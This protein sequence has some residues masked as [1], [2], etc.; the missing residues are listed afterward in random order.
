LNRQG[1]WRPHTASGGLRTAHPCPAAKPPPRPVPPPAAG[2]EAAD[3]LPSPHH[4]P[5]PLRSPLPIPLSQTQPTIMAKTTIKENNNSMCKS[6]T[7]MYRLVLPSHGMPEP[8]AGIHILELP[9]YSFCESYGQIRMNLY[10][11]PTACACPTQDSTTR[12][13]SYTM[14]R[15]QAGINKLVLPS[16]AFARRRGVIVQTCTAFTLHEQDSGRG[17]GVPPMLSSMMCLMSRSYDCWRRRGGTPSRPYSPIRDRRMGAL[18]RLFTCAAS[19]AKI[20]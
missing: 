10:C 16:S 9:P 20:A 8:H 1:G 4:V 5:N 15:S 14:C 18:T 7:G 3:G 12:T 6:Q 19:S 17:E 2:T 11:I 13:A